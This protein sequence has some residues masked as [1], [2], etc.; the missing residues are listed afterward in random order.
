MIA[1]PARGPPLWE[2][3]PS[4]SDVLG[5]YFAMGTGGYSHL[6]PLY[7]TPNDPCSCK[8]TEN[9]VLSN[10]LIGILATKEG[11]AALLSFKILLLEGPLALLE[12]KTATI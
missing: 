9:K 5:C 4:C 3:D 1:L 6:L 11:G 2:G 10:P 7:F 8:N 12:V